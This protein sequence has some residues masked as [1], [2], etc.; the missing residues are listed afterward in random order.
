MNRRRRAPP[1]RRVREEAAR[2]DVVSRA[3]HLLLDTNACLWW[4]SDDRRLGEATRAVIKAAPEVRFSVASLWEI[5]IKVGLSKVKVQRLA[6][7]PVELERDGFRLLAITIEHAFEVAVLPKT[8]RDPF[9]RLLA[10]QAKLE[11]LTLVTADP[12]LAE[13]DVPVLSARD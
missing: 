10:A 9:D 8:H 2:Y 11:G 5:A 12:I 1:R 13:Y 3:T 6:A 4:V 7:I